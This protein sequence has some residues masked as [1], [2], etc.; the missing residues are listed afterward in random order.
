MFDTNDLTCDNK[1][2]TRFTKQD[3]I[4]KKRISS[5]YNKQWKSLPRESMYSRSFWHQSFCDSSDRGRNTTSFLTS[6]PLPAAA[7]QPSLI[8]T[9][10]LILMLGPS[11]TKPRTSFSTT[12]HRWTPSD[13]HSRPSESRASGVSAPWTMT[14]SENMGC[15]LSG[16]SISELKSR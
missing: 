9:M 14:R 3:K 10:V 13:H 16:W 11:V 6:F 8:S 1:N 2:T 12:K 4:K 5:I 15:V 7:Q